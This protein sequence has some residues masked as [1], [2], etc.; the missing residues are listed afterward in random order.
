MIAACIATHGLRVTSIRCL[1]LS[2]KIAMLKIASLDST[3]R[4]ICF[5]RAGQF[6]S[7]TVK[8]LLCDRIDA[9]VQATRNSFLIV[10]LVARRQDSERVATAFSSQQV[11]GSHPS[12]S[13]SN[14][15]LWLAG[16]LEFKGKTNCRASNWYACRSTKTSVDGS[17]STGTPAHQNRVHS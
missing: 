3:R 10:V 12:W 14:F 11:V 2:K 9:I 7:K 13:F 4:Y 1:T 8:K 16:Q 15:C 17:G 6:I 5:S